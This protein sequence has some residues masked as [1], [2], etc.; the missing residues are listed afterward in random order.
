MSVLV[1]YFFKY[2]HFSVL[3]KSLQ[4]LPAFQSSGLLRHSFHCC[5][6]PSALLDS[7]THLANVHSSSFSMLSV[8]LFNDKLLQLNFLSFLIVFR[9]TL[10][11]PGANEKKIHK[12]TVSMVMVRTVKSR[13]KICQSERLIWPNFLQYNNMLY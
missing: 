9:A 5:F 2:W 11:F 6:R 3:L 4:F 12:Q 1:F 10:N 8:N 7:K 13:P